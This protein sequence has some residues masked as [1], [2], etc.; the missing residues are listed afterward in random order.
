MVATSV[1]AQDS[2]MN[3]RRL[4][5]D[6]TSSKQ[7]NNSEEF[8]ESRMGFSL[9]KNIALDRKAIWTSPFHLHWSDGTWLFPLAT[10]T[11]F[12]VASD[13]SLVHS[14]SD[15]PSRWS[16]YRSFSN[17]GVAALVGVGAGSYVWSFISRDEQERETGVLTG[18]AVIDSLLAT[19]VLKHSFGRERPTA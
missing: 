3:D 7:L 2:T 12:S 16:R 14:L 5:P 11:A 8:S 4:L 15:D 18:E 9:L 19:Q 10:V 13:R 1:R 6:Q 17:D